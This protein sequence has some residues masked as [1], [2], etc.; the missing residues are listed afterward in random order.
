VDEDKIPLF[1]SIFKGRQDVYARRWE[2]KNKSGYAPAYN[3]DW[4]R[5]DLHKAAGGTIKDY[6]HKTYSTFNAEVIKRHL[7]GKDVIGIYPLLENN[8]SWFVAV[9]FDENNWQDEII[10]LHDICIANH[11]PCYIERS[12]SGNGGHLWIFF[13]QPYPAKKS[14][15]IVK[16]LLKQVGINGARESSYDRIFPNQDYHS[17]KGLGNLIALPFQKKALENGNAAFINPGTFES[18][19]DQWGFLHCI[20]KVDTAILETFYSRCNNTSIAESHPR[21]IYQESG[22]LQIILDNTITISRNNLPNE[23]VSFLRDNLKANN[24]NYFIKK[25]TGQ[26]TFETLISTSVLEEYPDRLVMPRGYVG[27]LLRYCKANNID[28]KLIDQRNKLPEIEFILKG[29]LYDYQTPALLVLKKKQ[30]GVIVAPPGFGKTIIG[31]AII[32]QKKQPALI[33]V[34]RRQLFDQWVQS[35]QSF[36]GIPKYKIGRIAKGQIDIEASITVAMIQS[37]DNADTVTKIQRSFG[38]LIIDECHHLAADTYRSVL[39]GLHTYYIYGLTATPVRKNRDE[40]LVFAQIGEIIHEVSVPISGN[41]TGLSINVIDTDLKVPF[42]AGTDDFEMLSDMLIHDTARNSL[43]ADDIRKEINNGRSIIAITERKDH[44][45]ILNQFLKHDCET[46]TLSGDDSEASRKSKLNLIQEGRFQVLITTGQLMGEGVD[47]ESL[48]CLFIVYPCSFEGKLVQYIGRIE[49]GENAPMI[50]DYRDLYILR[51]E[52]MFQKRNKYYSKLLQTGKIKPSEEYLLKFEHDVFY[53]G[54]H[55]NP[56]PISILDINLNIEGFKKDI[57]WRIKV[58]KYNEELDSIFVEVLSYDVTLIEEPQQLAL[59]LAPIEQVCFRTLD[60][61]GLLKS[62]ALKS[63]FTT[64]GKT[65]TDNSFVL[66]QINEDN[67][68]GDDELEL[69]SHDPVVP[70]PIIEQWWLFEKIIKIPFKKV[71]FGNGVVSFTFYLSA[72]KKDIAI[73]IFN[74][75][76]RLEFEAVKEYFSRILKTKSVTANLKIKHN[77]FKVLSYEASSEEINAINAEIIDSVKFEFVRK[78]LFRFKGSADKIM[79]TFD[80]LT[81]SNGLVSAL[82]NDEAELLSEALKMKAAKHFLQLQYLAGKHEASVLKLRFILQPF[83]FVFLIAGEKKYHLI[84]ETLDS[85]E[86]TYLWHIDKNKDVLRIAVKEIE[87]SLNE[88]KQTGRNSYIKKAPAYFSRIIHDYADAKNGFIDWKGL[89][90]ERLV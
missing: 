88:M 72:I 30:M 51:L 69:K 48:D 60:T 42:N 9:D 73:E 4:N 71:Q 56:Y 23:M 85:E 90:E 11:F 70:E 75:D 2:S 22:E 82:L 37:L 58:L 15:D 39:Q 65:A 32:A 45:K 66:L 84:W 17:G 8:T 53:L 50:Y 67:K 41:K 35:I 31:L 63:S 36:L 21:V 33:I 24:P 55:A 47:I 29:Q 28:Y 16:G 49:R 26:N 38:I 6:P 76:I 43:I 77:K 68:K 13:E 7:E 57:V 86:A 44:I 81:Q 5:Y 80:E 52:K 27:A 12:R 54:N 46:V 19:S 61:A 62:V 79:Q 40:K 10:K 34:H 3:I 87:A 74:A 89:L 1:I 14:R 20:Q 78:D 25:A 83:S 59:P 18:Y 64:T